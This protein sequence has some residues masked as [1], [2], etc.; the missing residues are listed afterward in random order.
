MHHRHIK[1]IQFA[2]IMMT[3][4]GFTLAGWGEEIVYETI[5]A[6]F[7]AHV[8]HD[9]GGRIDWTAGYL[10]AEGKGFSKGEGKTDQQRL[11]ARRAATLDAAANALAIAAGIDVDAGG[12]ASGIANGRRRLEGCVKGHEV[13]S[14]TWEPEAARPTFRITLRVPLWGVK[15]VGSLFHDQCRK[16]IARQR[17]PRLTLAI[18][19]PDQ[20]PA[21]I[22]I[23]ARGTGLRPCLFPSVL[24]DQGRTLYDVTTLT[25]KNAKAEPPVR[26]VE[27]KMSFEQIQAALQPD[28]IARPTAHLAARQPE[29]KP[30]NAADDKPKKETPKK[31]RKRRRR[32]HAVKAIRA[33]GANKTK[34]VLT[35]TDADKLRLDKT[36]AHLLRNA[37]VVVVVDSAAAGIQ[38]LL[39]DLTDDIL[40]ASATIP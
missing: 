14:E 21:M 3:L 39:D 23:D 15:S 20:A 27:T 16:R 7:A 31:Q 10:L 40:L 1:Q 33:D 28:E 30:S 19:T 34:I 6:G 22:V 38:G 17:Q 18:G 9:A 29:A 26:Y 5:T 2:V 24:A 8:Q 13:V 25:A 37:E 12:R 36:S 35:A 11:M 32:R 4:G